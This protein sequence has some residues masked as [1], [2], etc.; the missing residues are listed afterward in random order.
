MQSR[1][2]TEGATVLPGD[3]REPD[4]LAPGAKA[5]PWIVRERL[6]QGGMG[7]VY[8]VMHEEIGKRAALK[9]MHSRLCNGRTVERTLVEAR[10]VNRVGHPNVVDIFETGT[11][12]DGR[13]YIV[14]ER[15]DGVSLC[16]RAHDS[17]LRPDAVIDILLQIGDA[18]I[19]AHAAGV[20][21][22]DLK[23]E[24]VFLV[25]NAED[26]HKP[27][28]KI[29]DWGIAKDL[30]TDAR[31]TIEGFL[32]GTPQYLSPEQARGDVLTTATDVYSLGVMAYELFMERLPF[33]ADTV[34]ETMTMHLRATPPPP[35]DLWPG[36][37]RALEELLLAML[38]KRPSERPTMLTVVHALELV[39]DD[40]EHKRGLPARE[41]KRITR[42]RSFAASLDAPARWRRGTASWK[43]VIGAGAMV[44]SVVGFLVA[45]DTTSSAA[46]MVG[47]ASALATPVVPAAM[48]VVQPEPKPQPD[49]N[50]AQPAPAVAVAAT[51]PVDPAITIDPPSKR[52]KAQQRSSAPRTPS[53]APTKAVTAELASALT[54]APETTRRAREHAPHVER[55]TATDAR[56]PPV[57]KAVLVQQHGE[58]DPDGSIE[59]YR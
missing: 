7:T 17:K 1:V 36:I 21:H 23:L 32:L 46:T 42:P 16:K 45:R 11:L 51:R 9:V 52:S 8:A 10:V 24:N 57:V 12:D 30:E 28:V 18:L 44:L 13:P 31:R 47:P 37:P 20:I 43:V 54:S 38:A 35:R 26:P 33:E 5:G 34:A 27:R 56:R 55:T 58:F 19:A 3:V 49:P 48:P 29:L 4:L 53:S 59:G 39:R 50:I 15:L 40:L 22:R 2:S 6:G 25:D 14:M 41:A